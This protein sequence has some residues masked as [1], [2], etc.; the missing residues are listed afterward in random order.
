MICVIQRVN[1]ATVYA[2]GGKILVLSAN[3]NDI[4]AETFD[5][6]GKLGEIT[7][8]P[9]GYW[10]NASINDGVVVIADFDTNTKYTL[11]TVDLQ[12]LFD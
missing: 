2:D 8:D 5:V 10:F 12:P 4:Y 1:N 7:F 3:G 11:Y 9:D 6:S